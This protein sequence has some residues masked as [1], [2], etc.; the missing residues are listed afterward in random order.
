MSKF[1]EKVASLFHRRR[2]VTQE[3]AAEIADWVGEGGAADPD[4][5]PRVD[6]DSEDHR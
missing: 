2:L 5:P 1:T 6:K 3:D 4:G